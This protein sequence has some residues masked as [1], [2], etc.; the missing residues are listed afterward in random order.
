MR[1]RNCSESEEV[2]GLTVDNRSTA[3]CL[4][5]LHDGRATEKGI[6][7]TADVIV[8]DIRRQKIGTEESRDCMTIK[9]VTVR[10]G[11]QDLDAV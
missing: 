7:G 4:S 9:V 5:S 11:L 3:Y 10:T 1:L 6:A 2:H 8:K